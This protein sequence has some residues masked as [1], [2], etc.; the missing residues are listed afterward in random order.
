MRSYEMMLIAR[1]DLDDAGNQA[2]LDRVSS[3]VTG[4][5]GAIEKMEPSKK[6]RLAYEINDLRE[7]IYTVVYFKGE[8]RTAEELTRVLKITDEVVRFM[9]VRP[10]E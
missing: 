3:L 5:G 6:Q 7:G 9:I 8:P 10:E 2:L 4:N 1:P